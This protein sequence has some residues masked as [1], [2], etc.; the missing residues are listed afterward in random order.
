MIVFDN[1]AHAA[2]L[3][4]HIAAGGVGLVSGFGALALRKG[5]PLHRLA[6]KIFVPAMVVMLGL[7]GVLGVMDGRWTFAVGVLFGIY[8]TLSAWAAARYPDGVGRHGRS[9]GVFAALIAATYLGLVILGATAG[10]AGAAD[11][12]RG[13]VIGVIFGGLAALGARTDF[14]AARNGGITGAARIR[15]HVWRMCATLFFASGSFFLGQMDEFPRAIQGPGWFVPAFAP[16]VL[17]VFW[18]WRYRDR[19]RRGSKPPAGAL[20][21]AA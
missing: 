10:P 6:G 20:P 14:R 16:L 4:T 3:T 18:L 1:P 21:E 2:L 13:L 17:M 12:S 5:S 19:K 15:R 9:L 7:G 8:L 11:G